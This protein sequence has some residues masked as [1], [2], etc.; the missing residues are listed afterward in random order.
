MGNIFEQLLVS[1]QILT[2]EDLEKYKAIQTQEGNKLSLSDFLL[3]R[4]VLDDI[5]LEQLLK[6]EK[7]TKKHL[8]LA[9]RQKKDRQ[10][11]EV[12][13][14]LG[15]IAQREI[16]ACIREKREKELQNG[17]PFLSDL[18]IQK[19][20]L[21]AYLVSKFYQRGINRI[22]LPSGVKSH[23][24]LIINIP[25]YLRDRLLAKIALK[26]RL[27]APKDLKAC[28]NILKKQWPKRSLSEIMLEKN[29][30]GEKKMKALVGIL[31][32]TVAERYPY[33]EAQIRDMQLARLLVKKNFL[34]PWRLNKCLLEQW[35]ALKQNQYF[36]LRQILI[37]KGYLSPYQFDTVLQEYG[38]LVSTELQDF[39]VPPDEIHPLKKEEIPTAVQEA[40]SDVHIIVEEQELSSLTL[41]EGEAKSSQSVELDELESVD[42]LEENSGIQYD[43]FRSAPKSSV[44]ASYRDSNMEEISDHAMLPEETISEDD[45]LDLNVEK[46]E[47]D[48]EWS[49][50]DVKDC[51]VEDLAKDVLLS[52]T[53]A[54]D[55]EEG[56][57]KF[58]PLPTEALDEGYSDDLVV[59][60]LKEIQKKKRDKA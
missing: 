44:P 24:D 53:D 1:N 49:K 30:M 23:E 22:A 38:V 16:A 40:Q 9:Q 27:V 34:S 11:L 58:P 52:H 12:V 4:G 37:D 33:L 41:E 18:F 7:D 42:R 48:T 55:L 14:K 3:K 47:L 45:I 21:T 57:E 46:E 8:K 60:D 2:E 26:N 54:V 15:I 25:Q 36:A 56:K 39:L 20:Y 10:V 31:K 5:Q 19:G 43:T 51:L 29:I 35:Q 32:K 50:E 17:S 28:W 59:E 13:Q 6:A